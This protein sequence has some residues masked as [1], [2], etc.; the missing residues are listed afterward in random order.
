MRIR[1][2]DGSVR[3]TTGPLVSLPR[4]DRVMLETGEDALVTTQ[5]NIVV[6]SRATARMGEGDTQVLTEGHGS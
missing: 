4:T 2:E 5:S 1:T 6:T 3:T